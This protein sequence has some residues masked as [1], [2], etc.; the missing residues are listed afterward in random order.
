M[1]TLSIA[2]ILRA[3]SWV[4]GAREGRQRWAQSRRQSTGTGDG[5]QLRHSHQ[6]AW[7]RRG[8]PC[9]RTWG[10]LK[11]PLGNG[12]G[13]GQTLKSHIVLGPAG[14]GVETPGHLTPRQRGGW[15]DTHSSSWRLPL[16]ERRQ[17][18]VRERALWALACRMAVGDWGQGSWKKRI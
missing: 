12:R 1:V 5:G 17:S 10:L 4:R 13:A 6:P 9:C 7:L 15:G 14:L 11:V 2:P 18:P 16:L 3:P 8:H